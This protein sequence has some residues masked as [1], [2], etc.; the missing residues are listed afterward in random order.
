MESM[1]FEWIYLDGRVTPPE[2]HNTMKFLHWASGMLGSV[3]IVLVTNL[4]GADDPREAAISRPR[5]T[6]HAKVVEKIILG[7]RHWSFRH[8]RSIRKH[9]CEA[10]N[11]QDDLKVPDASGY[12]HAG[13]SDHDGKAANRPCQSS[14]IWTFQKAFPFFVTNDKMELHTPLPS[15]FTASRA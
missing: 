1:G 13:D 12:P 5:L 8:C 10:H 4:S 14:R 3:Q 2:R 11:L 7:S 9:T 15:Q 6:C